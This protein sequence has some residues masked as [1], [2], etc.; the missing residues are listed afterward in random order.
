MRH[1]KAMSA[2]VKYPHIVKE[3]GKPARLEKNPR[4]RISLLITIQRAFNWSAEEMVQQYNNTLRLS[5][6]YS[7][8]AYYHDHK[9]EIDREIAD[10]DAEIKRLEKENSTAPTRAEL[11]ERLR[12]MKARDGL[13]IGN[14]S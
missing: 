6:I 8:L 2:A 14:A 3:E 5:E 10:D 1:F 13:K 12:K 4:W 9:E 11:E 7:A